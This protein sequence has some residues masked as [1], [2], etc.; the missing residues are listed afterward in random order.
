M[1]VTHPSPVPKMDR[2]IR[3]LSGMSFLNRL[4]F[5]VMTVTALWNWV[6]FY[7]SPNYKQDDRQTTPPSLNLVFYWKNWYSPF[8][9]RRHFKP[10]LSSP[11]KSDTDELQNFHLFFLSSV[12]NLTNKQ[13]KCKTLFVFSESGF[14]K[15]WNRRIVLMDISKLSCGSLRL[16]QQVHTSNV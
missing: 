8:L 13:T 12:T 5:T 10:S 7:K 14:I 6:S 15:G 11:V 1:S 3:V 9:Y 16:S 4:G 2:I